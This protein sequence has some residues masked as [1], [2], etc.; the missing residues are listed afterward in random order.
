MGDV[1]NLRQFKKQK[2]R[3]EKEKTAEANRRDHGR[4]KAEKQK[5]E[6]LRKIEQ[7][8]IDGHKLG[9]DETDSDT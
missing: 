9:T 3:A 8:R 1:V 5:T 4:T 7:D 6:A 2:D